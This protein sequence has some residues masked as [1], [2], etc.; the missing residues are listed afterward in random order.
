MQGREYVHSNAVITDSYSYYYLTMTKD[1]LR[2]DMAR[3]ALTAKNES[4]WLYIKFIN[5]GKVSELSLLMDTV[6]GSNFVESE[7]DVNR[8]GNLL[9]NPEIKVLEVAQ[10][11]IHPYSARQV[12]DTAFSYLLISS[13]DIVTS[14]HVASIFKKFGYTGSFSEIVDTPYGEFVLTPSM[15]DV[16]T[17]TETAKLQGKAAAAL[18][19]INRLTLKISSEEN[20]VQALNL[21]QTNF[22][23]SYSYHVSAM[24]DVQ[25]LYDQLSG[26]IKNQN[27]KLG[28]RL[29]T[30]IK[31]ARETLNALDRYLSKY[32]ATIASA[33]MAGVPEI[34]LKP[35]LFP[36]GDIKDARREYTD[37]LRSMDPTYGK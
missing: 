33:R 5:N 31:D 10:R 12:L 3:A 22:S 25:S 26:S 30:T 19:E 29:I 36:L 9:N 17:D 21:N 18:Y 23:A 4:S 35:Y 20:S 14:F 1:Q 27:K 28:G 15:D 37:Y 2:P 7:I 8:I 11:H 6:R 16:S 34:L 32:E 13:D 24:K